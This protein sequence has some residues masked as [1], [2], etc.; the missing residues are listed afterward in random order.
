MGRVIVI[1]SAPIDSQ[2][3]G[4]AR[5]ALIGRA[6]WAGKTWGWASAALIVGAYWAG[7]T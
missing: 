6:T 3:G 7:K 1:I 4:W 2:V 5:A